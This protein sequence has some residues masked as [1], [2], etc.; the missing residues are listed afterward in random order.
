MTVWSS[1][2]VNSTKCCSSAMFCQVF[3]V[4]A[5]F[6]FILPSVLFS[7][8]VI[9]HSV[10]N[11][12]LLS[13]CKKL[14]G[15]F[16]SVSGIIIQL[17]CERL[18]HQ[19]YQDFQLSLICPFL[20]MSVLCFASG[21]KLFVFTFMKTSLHHPTSSMSVFFTSLPFNLCIK[22]LIWP[23]LP[24]NTL[25]NTQPNKPHPNKYLSK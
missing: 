13:F 12:P 5:F 11:I 17:Y 18:F 25:T 21:H 19:F 1:E 16:L 22:L 7:V 14:S 23:R 9:T 24:N 2:S 3:S 20:F 6:L 8:S 10:K 4:T 15:G